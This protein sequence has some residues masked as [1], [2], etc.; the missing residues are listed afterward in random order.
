MARPG[1]HDSAGDSQST[2]AKGVHRRCEYCHAPEWICGYCFHIEHIWPKALHGSDEARNLAITCISCNLHKW[3][4][5]TGIDPRDETEH[6]LFHPR[7]DSWDDHF[8]WATDGVTLVGRT[9][10]GR[11]TIGRLKMN[12]ETRLEARRHWVK[13]GHL[14]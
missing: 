12:S 3:R 14:P 5:V 4:H 6:R 13:D 1:R 8:C 7:A 10:L 11:A 9:P 2:V